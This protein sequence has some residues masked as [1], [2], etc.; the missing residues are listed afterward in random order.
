M[1]VFLN[2]LDEIHFG[3]RYNWIYFLFDRNRIVTAPIWSEL[4][5]SWGHIII[6]DV[7]AEMDT[8]NNNYDRMYKVK[9]ICILRDGHTILRGVFY[10]GVSQPIPFRARVTTWPPP[11]SRRRRSCMI[12]NHLNS[13]AILYQGRRLSGYKPWNLVVSGFIINPSLHTTH[14]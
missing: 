4:Q 13:S 14:A 7:R 12:L 10:F 8:R 11:L 5:R 1:I 9:I 3:K 6:V 2:R